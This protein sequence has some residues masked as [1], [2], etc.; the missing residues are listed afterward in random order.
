MEILYKTIHSNQ[1]F[2]PIDNEMVIDMN[3]SILKILCDENIHEVQIGDEII[4]NISPSKELIFHKLRTSSK[5]HLDIKVRYLDGCNK[6]KYEKKIIKI[7]EASYVYNTNELESIKERGKN[8]YNN[9]ANG[10]A[11]GNADYYNSVIK[12]FSL[13][14]KEIENIIHSLSIIVKQAKLI[15]VMPKVELI[16]DETIRDSNEVKKINSNSARYFVMHPEDWYREGEENP[17]PLKMLTETFLENSN[18]YENQLVKFILYKC[19]LI[20]N[21]LINDL[22]ASKGII[23][24]S[25]MKD[26]ALLAQEEFT[27]QTKEDLEKSIYDKTLL[28]GNLSNNLKKL[29]SINKELKII[30]KDFYNITLRKSIKLKITQKILYDKRY[31]KIY[32]LYKKNLQELKFQTEELKEL[33]HPMIYSYMFIMAESICKAFQTLGISNICCDFDHDYKNTFTKAD[34]LE[35]YGNNYSG[36]DSLNF[37]IKL[38]SLNNTDNGII[39]NIKYKAKEEKIYFPINSFFINSAIDSEF[40]DLLYE[41]YNNDDFST[42]IICNTVDNEALRLINNE[43]GLK[44]LLNLSTL[45]NSF[46]SYKYYEKYGGFKEGMISVTLKELIFVNNKIIQLIKYKLVELGYYEYCTSCGSGRLMN[47]DDN[48]I[49]CSICHKR[50]AINRCNHCGKKIIKFLSKKNIEVASE[51]TEDIIQYHKE[52]EMKASSLGACYKRYY[53]NSGGFCAYCGKCSKL[54]Q[55]CTRCKVI[56]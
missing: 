33:D 29:K 19:K 3:S 10:L 32:K 54:D 39:L 25:L 30:Y 45:G 7:N 31:F 36:D 47:I 22:K 9:I 42:T 21:K 44:D 56:N 40:I 41:K 8:A 26:N 53:S 15:N 14:I 37:N 1:E 11:N 50:I 51:V 23:G 24:G 34:Y 6:E 17:K 4:K 49:E 38:N 12:D 18:I 46:S 2:I 43:E 48:L 5:N 20:N 16:E 28:I 27:F 55:S 52:Y 35:I 13:D